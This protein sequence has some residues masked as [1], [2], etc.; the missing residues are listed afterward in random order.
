MPATI[1]Q[2]EWFT[3]I[4]FA[5]CLWAF[6]KNNQNFIIYTHLIVIA[7]FLPIIAQPW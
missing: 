5:F 4:L 7:G 1:R 2:W 3:Q 6:L